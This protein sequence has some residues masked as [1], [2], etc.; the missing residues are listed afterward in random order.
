MQF[1]SKLS[2]LKTEIWIQL[3]L[4]LLDNIFNLIFIENVWIFAIVLNEF[5]N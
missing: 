2:I 5:F 1:K 3:F 4:F